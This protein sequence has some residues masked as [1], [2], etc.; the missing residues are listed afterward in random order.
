MES[1]FFMTHCGITN[2]IFGL[3][4]YPIIMIVLLIIALYFV[5][6]G[7]Q[8]EKLEEKWTKH[9]NRFKPLFGKDV[10]DSSERGHD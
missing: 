1:Q 9:K 5:N 7:G 4:V 10:N 8:F 3:P 2:Y 6:T